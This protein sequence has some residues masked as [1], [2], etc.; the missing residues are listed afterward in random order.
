[1]DHVNRRRLPTPVIS[2]MGAIY[3]DTSRVYDIFSH[4]GERLE[5]E[6]AAYHIVMDIY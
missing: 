3:C 6:I 5:V 2:G 1:M 4:P